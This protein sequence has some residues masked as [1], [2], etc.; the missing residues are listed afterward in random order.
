MHLL[1]LTI[2][3][4]KESYIWTF[5]TE[6]EALTWVFF[7]SLPLNLAKDALRNGRNWGE[8]KID[9]WE[10]RIN[11]DLAFHLVDLST[12]QGTSHGQEKPSCQWRHFRS[13]SVFFFRD[14]FLSMV[15]FFHNIIGTLL[16]KIISSF[17]IRLQQSL[18][19]LFQ[20][21]KIKDGGETYLSQ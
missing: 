11:E 20:S 2:A 16:S 3:F 5:S 18:P 15:F 19:A 1:F 9:C 21:N 14:Q 7:C 13:K 12:A 4:P 6:S 8:D 10:R 17:F